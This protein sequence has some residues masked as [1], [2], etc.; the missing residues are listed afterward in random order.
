M[1]YQIFLPIV[2]RWRA[3]RAGAPLKFCWFSQFCKTNYTHSIRASPGRSKAALSLHPGGGGD[4][5]IYPWVGGA[6]RP[7]ISWPWVRQN[8]WFSYPVYDRI[9]IFDTLFIN[10][11]RN[12]TLCKT[13]T[14]IKTL[15]YLILRQSQNYLQL[16]QQS[17]EE[18][19]IAQ[20]K[21][22]CL[23]QKLIKSIPFFRQKS[24]K[25]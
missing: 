20:E 16:D 10:L 14:N 18:L 25:T 19:F 17:D 13:I 5:F 1:V 22:P 8:R 15:S 7:L 6:A 2:L 4:Y 23:R 3:T 11:T 12:H 21:I 24:R 9:P